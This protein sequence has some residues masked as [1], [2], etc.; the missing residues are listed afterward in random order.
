M[1]FGRARRKSVRATPGTCA[2]LPYSRKMIGTDLLLLQSHRTHSFRRTGPLPAVTSGGSPE[3]HGIAG[4]QSQ[5]G[6]GP[7]RP[8]AH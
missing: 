7:T 4:Q 1:R 2:T 3:P 8:P 5:V 6:T